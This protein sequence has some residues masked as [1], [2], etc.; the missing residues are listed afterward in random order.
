MES[1]VIPRQSANRGA[2]KSLKSNQNLGD[3]Q[4]CNYVGYFKTQKNNKISES[5]MSYY[6]ILDRIKQ[7][8]FAGGED[9]E[10][11]EYR[12]IAVQ[13]FDANVFNRI[14]SSSMNLVTRPAYN[15]P[16]RTNDIKILGDLAGWVH[17]IKNTRIGIYQYKGDLL[18]KGET[19]IQQIQK[20]Y[21]ID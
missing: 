18:K 13:I 17:Y 20:E 9:G 19:L 4:I 11:N 12:K 2:V 5:I 10:M 7:L 6:S 8:E 16:L 14:N 1:P 21:H 3:E 15:P